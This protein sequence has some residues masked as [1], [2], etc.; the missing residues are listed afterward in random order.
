MGSRPEALV[1]IHNAISAVCHRTA[2][3]RRIYSENIQIK[4]LSIKF[5]LHCTSIDVDKNIY[6]VEPYAIKTLRGA[7]PHRTSTAGQSAAVSK[8]YFKAMQP[9]PIFGHK[10]TALKI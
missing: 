9:R 6:L 8:Y 10:K 5:P 7:V 2:V 3:C 4:V 1:L